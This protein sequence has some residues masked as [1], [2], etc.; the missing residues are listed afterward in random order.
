M[1]GEPATASR[2]DLRPLLASAVAA[3]RAGRLAEAGQL[4]DR[5]LAA[6]PGHGWASYFRGVLAQEADETETARTYFV[7]ACSALDAAPQFHMALGNLELT[8]DDAEAAAA[9]FRAAITARPDFAAAYTGMSLALKRLGRLDEA[10]E[11]VSRA[12]Q[13]RRGWQEGG[14]TPG[15]VDPA[16]VASMRRAHRVKLRHDI[17][18]LRYLRALGRV[19]LEI[20]PVIAGLETLLARCASLPDDTAIVEL[21]EADLILAHH[22]YNRAVHVAPAPR[23]ASPA[24]NAAA[25][26]SVDAA[27]AELPNGFIVVDSALTPAALESLQRLLTESTIW[28][29]VKDHGGHL[30]AYFEE[31]LACGLT[32]QITDELRALLPRTLGGRRLAQLWAYKYQQ[33]MG[34]TELHADIGAVSLNLWVTPDSASLDTEGGGLEIL[35]LAVPPDWDFRRMN[36]ERDALGRF[37]VGSGV[38]PARVAHRCNRMVVFGARLLHRTAPGRFAEGYPNKRTNVTFLFS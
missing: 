23:L 25:F 7:I 36:V 6:H 2:D 13:L 38:A 11:A 14:P 9:C 35:P 30:G 3:H 28:F 22:A 33:G 31:G 29:E 21:S 20:E 37:A 10:A 1:P 18:Q 27:C 16:E 19:G 12:V 32:A 15:F 26:A 17:A 4:Y 34:G 24:L 5:V 8:R